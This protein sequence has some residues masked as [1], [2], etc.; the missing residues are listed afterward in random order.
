VFAL[1]T[2]INETIA[3]LPA[4]INQIFDM[5]PDIDKAIANRPTTRAQIQSGYDGLISMNTSLANLPNMTTIHYQV[6]NVNNSL[7][8]LPNFQL[9]YDNLEA[10]NTSI[11]AIP[12]LQPYLDQLVALNASLTIPNLDNIITQLDALNNTVETMPSPQALVGSAYQLNNTLHNPCM[13]CLTPPSYPSSC[14]I[15]LCYICLFP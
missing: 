3:I 7:T 15:N 12:N 6:I 8:S 10:L 9:M 1:L 14:F 5:K 2:K 11:A 4:A 13:Y